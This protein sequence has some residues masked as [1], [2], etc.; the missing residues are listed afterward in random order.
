MLSDRLHLMI[1]LFWCLRRK[2]ILQRHR[3]DKW[4]KGNDNTTYFF[5]KC[6]DF[7]R[8][9]TRLFCRQTIDEIIKELRLRQVDLGFNFEGEFSETDNNRNSISPHI[10]VLL[11]ENRWIIAAGHMPYMRH[12]SSKLICSLIKSASDNTT[13]V[14]SFAWMRTNAHSTNFIRVSKTCARITG[15]NN[16]PLVFFKGNSA[17]PSKYELEYF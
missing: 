5:C 10:W 3:S 8:A 16:F 9:N 7:V 15:C 11:S 12:L 17:C 14:S 1:L 13:V 2:D 4:L 6:H